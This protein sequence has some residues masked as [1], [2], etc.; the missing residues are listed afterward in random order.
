MA[1]VCLNSASV[2]FM[3]SKK[4]NFSSCASAIIATYVWFLQIQSLSFGK[5]LEGKTYSFVNMHF[6]AAV[7]QIVLY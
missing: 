4:L 5:F 3:S 6:P 2:A 7:L 1:V